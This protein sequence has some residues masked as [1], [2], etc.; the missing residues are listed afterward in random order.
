MTLSELSSY[1]VE[2][3]ILFSREILYQV[4]ASY[5]EGLWPLQ[6]LWLGLSLLML[7]LLWSRHP[8]RAHFVP[9]I[10]AA[11]WLGVGV[12]FHGRFFMPVNWAAKYFAALFVLEGVLLLYFAWRGLKFSEHRGVE[13]AFGFGLFALSAFVPFQNLLFGWGP[14]HT[15]FGT[16]GILLMARG[17]FA[18][19]ILMLPPLLWLVVSGLIFYGLK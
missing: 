2:D 6:I 13:W 7:F 4:Y 15:S 12:V 3:F 10:L 1:R 9:A 17:R 16:L 14:D 5:N 18:R 19:W 8:R 11:A